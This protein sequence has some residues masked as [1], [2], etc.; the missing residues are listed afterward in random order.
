MQHRELGVVTIVEGLIPKR[1]AIPTAIV[2]PI[3]VPAAT[4]NDRKPPL[5]EPWVQKQQHVLSPN[6]RHLFVQ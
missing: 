1:G 6:Q 5:L 4:D 2:Q 3:L